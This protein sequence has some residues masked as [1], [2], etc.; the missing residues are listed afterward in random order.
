MR[1]DDVAISRPRHRADDRAALA[2]ACRP[3]LIGKRGLAPGAGCDVRRMWSVRFTPVIRDPETSIARLQDGPSVL[4]GFAT[5]IR[6]SPPAAPRIIAPPP[7]A[8][9]NPCQSISNDRLT[10]GFRRCR[11]YA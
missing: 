3:Q 7:A 1:A 2:R 8:E 4:E 10:A 9:A 5:L 11:G 6:R